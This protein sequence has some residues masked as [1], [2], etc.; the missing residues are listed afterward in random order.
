[1]RLL[2]PVD[3]PISSDKPDIKFYDQTTMK[4]VPIEIIKLDKG[5]ITNIF[6]KEKEG[7]YR[8]VPLKDVFVCQDFLE[9]PGVGYLYPGTKVCLD[10]DQYHRTYVLLQGWHT[11]ISNQRIFGW[12]LRPTDYIPEEDQSNYMSQ[13]PLGFFADRTLYEQM[14]NHLCKITP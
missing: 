7:T 2:V 13:L 10:D 12:F 8:E 4:E 11:N 6:V 14:I 9:V 5:H 1:M 3:S